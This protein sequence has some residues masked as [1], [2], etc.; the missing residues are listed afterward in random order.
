MP[1]F[2]T[3]I[4]IS[5]ASFVSGCAT[6]SKSSFSSPDE[7]RAISKKI[8]EIAREKHGYK[9]FKADGHF[10]TVDFVS[11]LAE[12]EEGRAERLVC[13]SQAP[14]QIMKYNA[15]PVS[16]FGIFSW[17][18]RSNIVNALHS[19]HGGDHEAVG[20]RRE[21]LELLVRESYGERKPDWQTGFLIHALGD[22]YAH[23]RGSYDSPTA[24]GEL[25]GHGFAFQNPDNIFAGENYR[26]YNAY[27]LSLFDALANPENTQGRIR[28]VEFTQQIE[29]MVVNSKS[30]P[31]DLK[32]IL[33]SETANG[34]NF[35][36]CY[37][38]YPEIDE[39]EAKNFLSDLA[40]R[41]RKR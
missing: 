41:L 28:L 33:L 35:N 32:P 5:C 19:L 36:S 22:S 7:P 13:F 24:Y 20:K 27:V 23:V 14:D 34:F 30:N 2:I 1:R 8:I 4:L 6:L 25:V 26:K 9:G 18:N 29:R 15:V 17:K 11:K 39:A 37:R 16:I 10:Y 3:A 12:I 38:F 40:E 31:K 21:A